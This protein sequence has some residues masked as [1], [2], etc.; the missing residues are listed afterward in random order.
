MLVIQ[1]EKDIILS[2]ENEEKYKYR[3]IIKK[4]KFK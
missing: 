2:I 4:E 1:M 3:I